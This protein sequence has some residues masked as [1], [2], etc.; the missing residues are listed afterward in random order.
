MSSNL[1]SQLEYL[2]LNLNLNFSRAIYYKS[3]NKYGKVEDW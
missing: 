2:N 1:N 3:I